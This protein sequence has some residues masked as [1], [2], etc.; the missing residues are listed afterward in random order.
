MSDRGLGMQIQVT[1]NSM[2]QL[3][4]SFSKNEEHRTKEIINQYTVQ[5]QS[6]KYQGGRL[7]KSRTSQLVALAIS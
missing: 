1:Q 2:F 3:G 4:N 7:Q 5:I 6:L